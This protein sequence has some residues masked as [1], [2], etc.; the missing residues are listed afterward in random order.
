MNIIYIVVSVI[1]YEGER[2]EFIGY[3]EWDLDQYLKTEKKSSPETFKFLKVIEIYTKDYPKW[4]HDL[5]YHNASN[6]LLD[7]AE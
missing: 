7:K 5:E 3:D 4:R 2:I 1:P 6:Y